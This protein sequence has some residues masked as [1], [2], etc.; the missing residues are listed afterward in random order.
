MSVFAELVSGGG[1][2][3]E[4]VTGS[5]TGNASTLSYQ[6]SQTINLGFQPR[7]VYVFQN[8]PGEFAAAFPGYPAFP[9]NYA[10][11]CLVVSGSG[12]TVGGESTHSMNV[13]G[14][15]YGYIAFKY[16]R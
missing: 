7:F 2:G 12:F 11:T 5:Y 15:H 16:R 10:G 4:F 8:V 13:N 9:T 14:Q 1:G 3:A 6:G